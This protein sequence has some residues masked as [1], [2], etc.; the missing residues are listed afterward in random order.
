MQRSASSGPLHTTAK[1]PS[2]VGGAAKSRTNFDSILNS[3]EDTESEEEAPKAPPSSR[4]ADGTDATKGNAITSRMREIDQELAQ[5][6]K[7]DTTGALSKLK[8]MHEDDVGSG[9]GSSVASEDI[10]KLDF[11]TGGGADDDDLD[12]AESS[13]E[14]SFSFL[15]ASA[16]GGK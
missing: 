7:A 13:G 9:D 15:D 5:Y 16:K 10:D 12:M 6:E 14:G 3:F 8:K 1:A 11:S 2:A 4:N